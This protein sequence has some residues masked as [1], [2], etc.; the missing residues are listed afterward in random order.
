[1]STV[2]TQ[3]TVLFEQHFAFWIKASATLA[4]CIGRSIVWRV[5]ISLGCGVPLHPISAG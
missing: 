2:T 1:M 4:S 5:L 3:I